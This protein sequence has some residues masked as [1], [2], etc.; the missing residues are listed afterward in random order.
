MTVEATVAAASCGGCVM[1]RGPVE[2]RPVAMTGAVPERET[3][4]TARGRSSVE[5]RRES[6]RRERVERGSSQAAAA[7][8]ETDANGS[9]AEK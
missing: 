2:D 4:R 7:V 1:G 9:A 8:G 6:E 5:R 3:R